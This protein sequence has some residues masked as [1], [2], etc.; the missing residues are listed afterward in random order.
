MFSFHSL[1][2]YYFDISHVSISL[3][4]LWFSSIPYLLLLVHS[5]FFYCPF[6]HLTSTLLS[7]FAIL[8]VLLEKYNLPLV[9]H[10][11]RFMRFTM[12]FPQFLFC[13]S[14]LFITPLFLYDGHMRLGVCIGGWVCAKSQKYLAETYQCNPEHLSKTTCVN[15][16]GSYVEKIARVCKSLMQKFLWISS[17]IYCPSVMS[18]VTFKRTIADAVI[19][20]WL[21]LL[22]LFL[23]YLSL[24][25]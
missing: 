8:Y 21:K 12:V 23:L 17:K 22:F 5:H 3:F 19:G 11:S 16:T 4:Y 15:N 1:L 9:F 13:L 18:R 10:H 20:N 24:V 14:A 6:S 2:F 7:H 25:H